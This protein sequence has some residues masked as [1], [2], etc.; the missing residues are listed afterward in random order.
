MDTEVL[1]GGPLTVPLCCAYMIH[2]WQRS[3]QYPISSLLLATLSANKKTLRAA[4][5]DPSRPGC[6]VVGIS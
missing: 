5:R 4:D 2:T 3:F 1:G 6:P